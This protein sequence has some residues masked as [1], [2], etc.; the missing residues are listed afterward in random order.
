MNSPVRTQSW[1][2]AAVAVGVLVAACTAPPAPPPPEGQPAPRPVTP[3]VPPGAPSTKPAE[4]QSEAHWRRALAQHIQATNRERV[5]EGSPPHPLRAIVVLELTI[6]ADGRLQR[7]TVLRAP[8][9]ARELGAEAIRTAQAASPLPPPPRALLGRGAARL[10]ETW[11]FRGD[12]RFQLRTL[13]E[14]QLIQ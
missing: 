8:D 6:G 11:L 12:N 2:V 13:A 14:M 7:A 10:T 1:A 4:P 9:H 3:A 5:F